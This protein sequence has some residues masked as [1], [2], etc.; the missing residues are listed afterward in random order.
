M[1]LQARWEVREQF[2]GGVR[3]VFS[4]GTDG[5]LAEEVRRMVEAGLPLCGLQR[6]EATMEEIFVE[7]LKNE[8]GSAK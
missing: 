7:V 4:G 1:E 5:M 8:G 6:H 3:A 2:S